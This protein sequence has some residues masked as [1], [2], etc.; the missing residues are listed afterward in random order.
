MEGSEIRIQN[1]EHCISC[2]HCVSVC[3]TD[4]VCHGGLDGSVFSPVQEDLRVAPEAMEHFLR[5][6][7]SCRAYE[8]RPLPRE[9]LEELIDIARYAPTGHNSQNFHFIVLED[10]AKIAT[11]S[12]MAAEF[13]GN[14]A[15]TLEASRDSLPEF[16]REMIYGFRLNHEFSRQGRDRVFR[17]APNVILVHAST[18]NMTSPDNCLYAVFHMVMMAH[19]MGIGTCINRYFVAAAERVAEIPRLLEIPE[20]NKIM[21]CLTL[22]FPRHGHHRLPPRNLPQVRWM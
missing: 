14:L 11:L 15:Q 9:I 12:R 2:G 16:L 21:G 10:P 4:A 3:P 5:S 1:E 7:R 20:G 13:F 18:E 6:R 19:A 17:G 8:P 22:G